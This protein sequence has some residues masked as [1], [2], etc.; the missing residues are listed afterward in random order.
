[1]SKYRDYAILT[2]DDDTIYCNNMIKSLFNSYLDHPNIVSGRAGHFMKYKDNGELTGY[3]SWFEPANSVED[4]DYNI[5][6]IG[7]GGI[8]YPPDILNINE[9]YL[10]II[11]DFLIGDDFV[12]KHLEIKKGIEQRLIKNNH[13][14]GLYMKNNSLNRPLYAINN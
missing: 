12:L 11:R 14:Q 10:D 3:L 8:I 4:I 6:L 13:P 9:N 1:M 7:V 5:F 2:L